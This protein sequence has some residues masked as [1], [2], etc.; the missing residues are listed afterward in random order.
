MGDQEGGE[1]RGS[2]ERGEDVELVVPVGEPA[3]ERGRDEGGGAAEEIDER[4][5]FGGDA[6]VG[7]QAGRHEGDHAAAGGHERGGDGEGAPVD[8]FREQISHL[9]ER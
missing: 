5:E 8:R 3:D 2:G 4:E 1:N 7:D 9:G 6:G